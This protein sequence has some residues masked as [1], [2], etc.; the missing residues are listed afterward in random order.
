VKK[1]N[2]SEGLKS[3][4][5]GPEVSRDLKREKEKTS[6]TQKNERRMTKER[7]TKALAN[8][9][10]ARDENVVG[11]KV[12]P[13]STGHKSPTKVGNKDVKIKK[14][15]KCVEGARIR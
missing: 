7:K 6:Q 8:F 14:S 11:G 4:E 5:N 12:L 1:G 3:C 15:R 13:R 10:K 2:I 9:L